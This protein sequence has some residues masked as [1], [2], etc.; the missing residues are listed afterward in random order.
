MIQGK[1]GSHVNQGLSPLAWSKAH[2]V[3]KR[4][5]SSFEEFSIFKTL[6]KQYLF[7]TKWGF[8][9]E[10]AISLI[11]LYW[12]KHFLCEVSLNWLTA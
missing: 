1:L 3:I 6:E 5:S 10:I 2:L 7:L 4:Q 11:Y 9:E 12:K 8:I